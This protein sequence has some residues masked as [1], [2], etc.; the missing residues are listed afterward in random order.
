[1]TEAYYQVGDVAQRR[2][3]AVPVGRVANRMTLLT[4]LPSWQAIAPDT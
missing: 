1:M 2:D 4:S 3:A